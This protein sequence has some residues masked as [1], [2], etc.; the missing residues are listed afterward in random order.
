MQKY[1]REQMELARYP[2]SWI[3]QLPNWKWRADM[4]T[5]ILCNRIERS[6][7]HQIS[8]NQMEDFMIRKHK[9]PNKLVCKTIDWPNI[10]KA[11]TSNTQGRRRWIA[12]NHVGMCGVNKWRFIW[13]D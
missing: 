13:N 12:K 6:L 7:T 2:S 8:Y 10:A 5:S 3:A 9:L 1:K 4:N 11:N